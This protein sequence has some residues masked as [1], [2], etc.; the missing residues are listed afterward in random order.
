MLKSYFF[1]PGSHS[2]LN[3]KIQ[4]I[5][6]DFIIVDIEDAV[7]INDRIE[8]IHKLNT[9]E[10]KKRI[11]I[12]PVIFENVEELSP[13]FCNLVEDGFTNFVLPKTRN[14]NNFLKIEKYIA[15]YSITDISIIILVENPECLM[16][17]QKIIESTSIKIH[18][19][20]FGSQDY[21]TET[22]MKHTYEYLKVPRF[23]IMNLA[24]AYGLKCIDIACMDAQAGTIF[25]KEL[26]EAFEMG[27][28]GKFLIHPLQLNELNQ[29]CFFSSDDVKIAEEVIDEYIRLG[30]PA[31]FV[32]DNN[33]IEPPHI[34]QFN[35]IL[36]WYQKH[37]SK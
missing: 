29:Y 35:K 33:V 4:T 14:H 34:K 37:E 24:K 1:I 6:A 32:Y 31:V 23:Q 20:G 13:M 16:N 12:R 36:D 22:G 5:S 15:E 18:G 10:N 19:I 21:C 26:R 7:S 30:Q 8:A 11:W 9:I 27:Y 2:K 25:Q 28:D 3:E 17:L